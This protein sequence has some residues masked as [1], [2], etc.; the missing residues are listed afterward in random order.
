VSSLVLVLDIAVFVL[1]AYWAY[2]NDLRPGERVS[3]G[4]FAMKDEPT[5]AVAPR[6][7]EP[8]WRNAACEKSPAAP[9]AARAP[10]WR[11]DFRGGRWLP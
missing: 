9:P 5:E 6:G 4:P 11:Q 10:R 2:A 8:R 7:S 1:L 3:K